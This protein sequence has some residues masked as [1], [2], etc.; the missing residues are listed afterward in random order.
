MLK[1]KLLADVLAQQPIQ[2]GNY[3]A[4]HEKNLLLLIKFANTVSEEIWEHNCAGGKVLLFQLRQAATLHQYQVS[5]NW[6]S[7]NNLSTNVIPF[8]K[9]PFN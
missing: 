3:T 8:Q 1:P 2:A 7:R 9:K 6:Y 5:L 4:G